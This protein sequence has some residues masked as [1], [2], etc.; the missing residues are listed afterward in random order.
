[1]I[2]INW[3]TLVLAD[4]CFWVSGFAIGLYVSRKRAE[5]QR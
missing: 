4:L 1:V 2:E 5:N 3:L